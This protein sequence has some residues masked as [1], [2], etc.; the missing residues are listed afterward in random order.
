MADKITKTRLDKLLFEKGLVESREKAKAVI[1]EGH[2]L[3]N[4]IVVDKAGALVKSDDD[5]TVKN[6]MP[7]VS[8]GGQ[9]LEHAIRHFDIDVKDKI[10][11]D[12]GAS[13][14]GFTDCLLKHDAAKVYAIDVGY[15]QFSW[16]LRTDEKVVLL[17]K[18]NI[19]Y[20][21]KD[22]VYDEIDII[23]ID[24]SFISLLKVIPKVLEFLKPSGAIVALIKP[25]FEA[26]R[27][28]IGKGGVIRNETKRL[29]IVEKIKSETEKMGLK[30]MGVIESPLKGPKGNVEYLIYLK[31]PQKVSVISDSVRK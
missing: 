28:D 16:I 23:T 29:E 17:E 22:L 25:Q 9:K 20:I 6:K 5:L 11:M 14:G 19:R 24:V 26:G 4:G 8:R 10:A 18:T 15:G 3:V 1:L 21:D 27:K 13:T 31:R 2:V 7:Y 12:V 30:V